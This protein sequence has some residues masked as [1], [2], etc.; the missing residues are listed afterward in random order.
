MGTGK[1]IAIGAGITV[2][3][4]FVLIIAVGLSVNSSQQN[5]INNINNGFQDQT[6]KTP[7]QAVA[8]DQSNGNSS[9]FNFLN[10]FET[11]D[12]LT[13]QQISHV[14]LVREQCE[15]QVATA[16]GLSGTELGNKIQEKCDKIVAD[17]IAKFRAENHD[18][19]NAVVLG[20]PKENSDNIAKINETAVVDNIPFRVTNIE[21]Y[22]VLLDSSNN[23][24]KANGEYVVADI[25]IGN[26]LSRSVQITS[27]QFALI[28]STGHEISLAN[29]LSNLPS[30]LSATIT[31]QPSSIV[32]KKL[33]FEM[34]NNGL[35]NY[36]LKIYGIN[37]TSIGG[38]ILIGDISG[39]RFLGLSKE[40]ISSI[41]AF[42]ENCQKEA[43]SGS[44]QDYTV[45][46]NIINCQELAASKI[47]EFRG[48]NQ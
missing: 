45:D 44:S 23:F 39:V 25:E 12:G 5:T 27:N 16:T 32:G 21:V 3:A 33:Y 42:E 30:Q 37:A 46:F 26:R 11:Y 8:T 35:G 34:P 7:S 48:Q 41:E 29:N 40:Q 13:E 9:P 1:K 43:V 22:T 10:G 15:N 4:L 19:I 28:D 18:D 20:E 6:V 47:S 38:R 14:K 36:D 17:E 24:H 31:I 2:G